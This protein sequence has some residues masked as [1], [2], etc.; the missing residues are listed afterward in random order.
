[1]IE[2]QKVQLKCHR[3]RVQD[4]GIGDPVVMV[5]DPSTPLFSHSPVY[6]AGEKFLDTGKGDNLPSKTML[7]KR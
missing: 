5:V 2:E 4:T 7:T 3:K 1:M 6:M